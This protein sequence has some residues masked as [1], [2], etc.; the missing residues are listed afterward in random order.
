MLDAKAMAEATAIIIREA[1]DKATT[2]LLARLA[3]VEAR[4]AS[5]DE[6]SIRRMID[7]AIAALPAPRDRRQLGELVRLERLLEALDLRAPDDVA[8]KGGREDLPRLERLGPLVAMQ[9]R[10]HARPL[11]SG[12][13]QD[14]AG[15]G[16]LERR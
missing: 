16:R 13:R 12:R 2:P 1:V 7:D 15:Y 9:R 3:I 10:Q 11:R 6:A 8:E 14:R 5:P 4:D